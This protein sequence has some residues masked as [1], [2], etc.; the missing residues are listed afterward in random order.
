MKTPAEQIRDLENTRA[1]K[2]AAMSEIMQKSAEAGTTLDAEQAATFDELEAELKQVDEDLARWRKIEALNLQKAA[3]VAAAV[4]SAVDH[5][6]HATG[7]RGAPAIH[8]DRTP[9]E[10]FK[11]QFFTQRVIAKALARM[12]NVPTSAIAYQRFVKNAYRGQQNQRLVDVIKANEVTS[13]GE[14][15]GEWG[16]EL[17]AADGRYT[18]DFIEFLYS[19]TIYDQIGLREVPA[20]VTIKGQDG[21]ATG[22]WVGEA[23]A[24]PSS[25][26][27]FSTINL[28]PLKVA[29]LCSVSKELLRDSSPAA[30]MLIRDALVE[31]CAQKVDTTFLS[32]AALS[33]GISPAGILHGLGAISASGTTADSLRY[34]VA[35]LYASFISA[36]NATGLT[37][38]MG[39]ALAKGISLLTNALGQTEFP[40]LNAGGG[41]LLGDRVVTG[42]NVGA[43]DFILLKP[44][45]IWKI[46]DMGIEVSMS[47]QATIEASSA[48][49][50]NALSPIAASANI[51]SMFQEDSIAFKVVRP[52]NFQ[53]RRSDAVAYVGDGAYAPTSA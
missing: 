41:V 14:T 15:T 29:A 51:Q 42:D 1:A 27:S 28:S 2:A 46:G 10:K 49:L 4:G 39:T 50:G 48:P 18:G 40:G 25:A 52:I 13:G 20:N 47:D 5:Q 38:V 22:Y 32:T 43:G 34:D 45:D 31:A 24:I 9:E 12:E 30:E 11:G 8:M 53:L 3:P 21:A 7:L 37:M 36:K 44:S 17:V 19:R 16:A 35:A 26:P 33:A 6:R 23:K